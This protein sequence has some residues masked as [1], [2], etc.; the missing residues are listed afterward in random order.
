MLSE[1]IMVIRENQKLPPDGNFHQAAE[2][3][4]QP[5]R[6]FRLLQP[7]EPEQPED[8]RQAEQPEHGGAASG[9]EK[10]KEDVPGDGGR[11]VH[12]PVPDIV[13]F[14]PAVSEKPGREL[15]GEKGGKEQIQ[16]LKEKVVEQD[17][18]Y[19]G[20][21]RCRNEE[22]QR[23]LHDGMPEEEVD[24]PGVSALVR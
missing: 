20:E 15:H 5:A 1:L 18:R 7:P 23:P 21:N 14:F 17:R 22:E 4:G 2:A 12:P 11:P 24:L 16:P 19:G 13:L 10:G 3:V 6:R 8:P 9:K